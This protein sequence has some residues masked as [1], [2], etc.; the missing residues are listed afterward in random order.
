MAPPSRVPSAT[1]LAEQCAQEYE[2]RGLPEPLPATARQDLGE[3]AAFFLA[4]DQ[5]TLLINKLVDWGLFCGD[6]NSGHTAIADFVTCGACVCAITTNF[7]ILIERAAVPLGEK[8]LQAALDGDEA[9]VDRGYRPLLK[10]HGCVLQRD[11]TLWCTGQLETSRTDPVSKKIR[12]RLESSRA[13]MQASLPRRHLVLI[14]FWSDWKYLNGVLL[15]SVRD[16]HPTQILLV[17]RATDA[18]LQAKAPE[19]WAW[20]SGFGPGFRHVQENAEAFLRE[21]QEIF[22][23]D[24]LKRVLKAA[25]DAA[26]GVC[27]DFSVVCNA[28]AALD[29]NALYALRRDFAGAPRGNVAKWKEPQDWMN[30]VG[31]TH[32]R[33]LLS[34]ARLDGSSYLTSGA[35]RVRVVNGRTLPMSKVRSEYSKEPTK[36]TADDYVICAAVSS[37]PGP[38]SIIRSATPSIV[39]PGSTAEWLTVEEARDKG[40]L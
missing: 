31:V 39:R 15:E 14:G 35:K 32:L 23:R 10:I 36:A 38:P 13:W 18:E 16:V 2:A 20:A 27:G 9:N 19:L 21:L 1:Q 6:S 17:D 29:T 28:L 12:A 24:I 33:M 11:Y 5:M 22:S 34:G 26:P 37:G 8:A 40:I 4:M 25:A 30:E 3:L 7:D